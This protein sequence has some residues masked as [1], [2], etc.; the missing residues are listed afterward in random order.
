MGA[1]SETGAISLLIAL[2]SKFVG[3]MILFAEG[4]IPC[5]WLFKMLK[6]E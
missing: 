2:S 4:S 6:V 5:Y 1:R 3:I